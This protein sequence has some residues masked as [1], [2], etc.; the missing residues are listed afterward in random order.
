MLENPLPPIALAQQVTANEMAQAFAMVKLASYSAVPLLANVHNAFFR[1]Y[2]INIVYVAAPTIL[3]NPGMVVGRVDYTWGKHY[4]IAFCGNQTSG[5]AF[6][7]FLGT[8]QMV[9]A[10]PPGGQIGQGIQN[11]VTVV[12]AAL[13]AQGAIQ[14]DL[15]LPST[16]ITFAGFSLGG[17]VAEVMAAVAKHL[18]PTRKIRL[19]KFGSINVG[20]QA[21]INARPDGLDVACMYR[22]GDGVWGIPWCS[23]VQQ[24]VGPVASWSVLPSSYYALDPVRQ[25]WSWDGNIAPTPRRGFVSPDLYFTSQWLRTVDTSNPA[26]N[27]LINSYRLLLTNMLQP[28]NQDDYYRFRF[29]EFPDDNKWQTMYQRAEFFDPTWIG[30]LDPAPANFQN[31]VPVAPVVRLHNAVP[32]APAAPPIPPTPRVSDNFNVIPWEAVFGRRRNRHA[33]VGGS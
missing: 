9:N 2:G 32:P 3:G 1:S 10:G 26:Y 28:G 30:L 15:S 6:V 16:Q 17:A 22:A 5:Q 12:A 24:I 14:A 8:Q 21:W 31:P 25:F 23:T 19:R 33:P 18:N 20:N 29:L 11:I 27:H 7:N 4:I 13:A